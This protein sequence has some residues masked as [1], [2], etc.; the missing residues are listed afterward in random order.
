MTVHQA[1]NAIDMMGGGVSG[2]WNTDVKG[3]SKTHLSG[4]II[5]AS[6]AFH[7]IGESAPGKKF[8]SAGKSLSSGPSN[9]FVIN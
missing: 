8:L 3:A 4:Y 2:S 6:V 1:A 9:A 7:A 5:L